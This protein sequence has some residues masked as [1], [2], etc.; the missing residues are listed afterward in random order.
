MS[1][2]VAWVSTPAK[3]RTG[4]T[5]TPRRGCA[6]ASCPEDWVTLIKPVAFP[7]KNDSKLYPLQPV[8]WIQIEVRISEAFRCVLTILEVYF[9]QWVGAQGFVTNPTGKEDEV[10]VQMTVKEPL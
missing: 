3:S 2:D 4:E 5:V 10:E 6:E 8:W 9:V 7:R 1:V